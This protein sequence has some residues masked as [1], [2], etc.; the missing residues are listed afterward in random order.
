MDWFQDRLQSSRFFYFVTYSFTRNDGEKVKALVR[1][2][3]S[4][5]AWVRLGHIIKAACARLSD[6]RKRRERGA[7]RTTETPSHTHSWMNRGGLCRQVQG[8]EREREEGNKLF[9]RKKKQSFV[10]LSTQSCRKLK[11][12]R[13][14]FNTDSN[15]PHRT[16][17]MYCER[18][19]GKTPSIL[20]TNTY[21]KS[22]MPNF[23]ILVTLVFKGHYIF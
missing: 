7:P 23:I 11:L 17:R 6:E 4:A 21:Y 18:L 2:P 22:Y 14:Y 10:D 9:L 1:N 20:Y 5:V 3:S 16:H 13:S 19:K 12:K 15:T 8:R